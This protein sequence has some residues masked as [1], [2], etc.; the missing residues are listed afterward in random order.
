M[1]AATVVTEEFGVFDFGLSE[2]QEER[3]AR[4][5]AE[6]MIVDMLFQGP[7]GARGCDGL[8][9]PEPTGDVE[10]DFDAINQLPIR[11]A[12]AGELE[13]FELG[14]RLSG[15]TAGNVQTWRFPD[16]A[17]FSIAHAQFDLFPWFAKALT[18]GDIR[19]A[20]ADGKI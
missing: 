12:L 4:L 18:A 14:W 2:E 3:A 17:G 10:A 11:R 13:A 8:E 6:S 20:K 16:I 1:E 9:L 5:H 15:L 19:Q 7:C